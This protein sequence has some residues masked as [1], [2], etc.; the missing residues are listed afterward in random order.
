MDVVLGTAT[1]VILDQNSCARY[2]GSIGM[3]QVVSR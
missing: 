1:N 3:D 2:K